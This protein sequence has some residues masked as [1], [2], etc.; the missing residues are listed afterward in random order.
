MA[1]QNRRPTHASVEL[2]DLPVEGGTLRVSRTGRG[3]KVVLGLHGL[4]G[5]RVTIEPVA[6]FLGEAFSFYAPDLRGRGLSADLAGPYGIGIHARDCARLLDQLGMKNIVVVGHSMGAMVAARLAALR[7]DLV[8]AIVLMDGGL[9]AEIPLPAGMTIEAF[10]DAAIGPVLANVTQTFPTEEAFL[11]QW[12]AHPAWG[13]TWNAD[14]EARFRYEM[15]GTAPHI[16]S[17]TSAEAL[18][19][20]MTDAFADSMAASIASFRTLRCPIHV[21]RAPRGL[22]NQPTPGLSDELVARWQ[23]ELPQLVDTMVADTNHVTLGALDHSLQLIG[24]RIRE[25]SA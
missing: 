17:R 5:S 24:A 4:A 16:R 22:L 20:D 7:P 15:G 8:R 14:I 2:L 9:P 3:P 19:G 23:A 13:D 12:Q 21:F 11:A 1:G 6:R 25:L 18:K 10:M